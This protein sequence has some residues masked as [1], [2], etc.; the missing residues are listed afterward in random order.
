MPNAFCQEIDNM[1]KDIE[2]EVRANYTQD[3]NRDN[4]KSQEFE[5]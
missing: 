1:L 2:N 5:C 4:K 3:Q